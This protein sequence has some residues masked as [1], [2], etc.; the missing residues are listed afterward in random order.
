MERPLIQKGWEFDD[1]SLTQMLTM[2]SSSTSG[3]C[4]FLGETLV[5]WKRKKA[6]CKG[7]SNF[8]D[9]ECQV[10]LRLKYEKIQPS[11]RIFF[12]TNC[13][14]TWIL[15]LGAPGHISGN[16]SSFSFIYFPKILMDSILIC[17]YFPIV[18]TI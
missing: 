4:M 15:D 13:F 8:S 17:L 10:Y 3:Y 16:R 14:S 7:L 11:S 9:D 18:L 1:E 6:R 2:Q 12:G 5:T